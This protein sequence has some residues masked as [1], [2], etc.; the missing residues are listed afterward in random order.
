ME[1]LVLAAAGSFAGLLSVASFELV[2][3]VAQYGSLL[4]LEIFGSHLHLAL[5]VFYQL[6]AF[7]YR[8]R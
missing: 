5:E 3:L 4:K 7:V 6:G 1:G 2:Y 8:V